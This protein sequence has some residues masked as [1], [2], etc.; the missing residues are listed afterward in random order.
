MKKPN[1]IY[2]KKCE[3]NLL[4][5][6]FSDNGINKCGKQGIC[7]TCWSEVVAIRNGKSIAMHENDK[8]LA[9]VHD[10]IEPLDSPLRVE[11]QMHP[12][13]FTK[14]R[15]SGVTK[16]EKRAQKRESLERRR[17]PTVAPI[18]DVNI[19]KVMSDLMSGNTQDMHR[20]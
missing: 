3:T 6:L 16:S 12:I 7:K 15:V 17:K 14:A 9:P 19:R 5:F 8:D 1:K 11:N 20:C 2:C 10:R 4:R 18:N 13:R